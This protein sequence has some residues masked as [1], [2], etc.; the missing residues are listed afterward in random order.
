MSTTRIRIGPADI[1]RR[2]TLE[3]F[4]EADEQPGYL[5]ELARGVLEVTNIPG[6]LHS[7]I[8]DNIHE[9]F[10]EYRRQ[11]PRLIRRIGHGSD[12]RYIIPE[13][14]SDRHPDLA[15]VF[16]DTPRDANRRQRA[17]L[18]V[19]VVSPGNRARKR[20]YE[21]KREEYLALG[22][23]EYW[24]VDPRLLRITVLIR[25]GEAWAERVFGGDD[26]IESDLLP[27][28]GCRVSDLWIDAD[29]VDDEEVDV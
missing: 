1:G 13:L 4:H 22:L 29:P 20:D 6:D 9:Q 28:L 17:L 5:Y 26:V 12:I 11:H 25:L 10:S 18:A 7:Q 15:I 24:I 19:E 21:A 3:E 2:M 8:V 14:E 23:A 16:R 27:G